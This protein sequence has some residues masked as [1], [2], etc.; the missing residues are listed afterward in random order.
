[1]LDLV[2][3]GAIVPKAELVVYWAPNTHDGWAEALKRAVYD[4]ELPSVISVS[5]V[6]DEENWK[7]WARQQIDDALKGA[8]LRGITVCC[9]AGD[10]GTA[11]PGQ[12]NPPPDTPP[13][14]Y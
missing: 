11:A 13:H 5:W 7:P 8:A 3:I 9:A 12:F 14:V 2:I 4:V 10:W 6:E 1:M